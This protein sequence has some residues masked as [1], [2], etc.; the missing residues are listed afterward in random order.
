VSPLHY[1]SLNLIKN[2]EVTFSFTC[3]HT[4]FGDKVAM[5][6]SIP[7]LGHWDPLKAVDMLTSD[8]SYPVW[9]IK[10][11]L[12]RDSVIEYKYLLIKAASQK[13]SFNAL[14]KPEYVQE[15]LPEGINRVVDTHGKKEIQ[16]F[17]AFEELETIEEYVEVHP[18]KKK[19]IM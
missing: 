6:G 1:R 14:T 8:K 5:V 18:D 7:L 12:P 4:S 10:I 16:I 19:V 11:D 3:K 13:K 17:D 15:N 2:T 9:T